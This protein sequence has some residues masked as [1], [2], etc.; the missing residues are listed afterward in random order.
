[1]TPLAFLVAAL[2][3]YRVSYLI[4]QEEGPLSIIAKVRGKIDPDQDNWLGRGVRCVACV[5]FWVS[6][7]IVLLI[8]AS[9]LEWLGVAGGA[10]VIH[11][12][13]NGR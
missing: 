11:K 5:S 13:V 2:A 3:V 8:G 6:L 9:W 12:A 1:M 7:I 10:L 4:A